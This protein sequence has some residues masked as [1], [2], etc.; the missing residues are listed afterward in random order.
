MGF[1][2]FV[3]YQPNRDYVSN[4]DFQTPPALARLLVEHFK[5]HRRMLK[6]CRGD[7]NILRLPPRGRVWCEIKE[8]YDFFAWNHPVDWIITIPSWS[9]I[10]RFL[11]YAMG[12]SDHVVFLLTINHVW[13]I[14]RLR[15]I[16][17]AGFVLRII[18]VDT[19]AS[20]PQSGFQIGAVHVARRWKGAITLAETASHA[21]CAKYPRKEKQ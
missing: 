3:R 14:A 11:Q 1:V 9:Q 12:L 19:S 21:S 5:R 4:G 13:T 7:S 8:D 6:P 20:F 17:A 15:D 2:S 16:R 10:R 18:L